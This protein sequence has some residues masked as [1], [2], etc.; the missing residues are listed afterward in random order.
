MT[1]QTIVTTQAELDAALDAPGEIII[2]SPRGVWLILNRGTVSV[3]GQSTVGPVGGSATVS[4]VGGSATVRGVWDSATVSDVWGSATVSGVGDSATVRDVGGS[5]TVH[6]YDAATAT[7]VGSHVA[8]HLHSA[9][10]TTDGGVVIDVAALDLTDIVTWAGYR[11]TRVR[12]GT[13]TAYKAVGADWQTHRK[14]WVYEPGATVTAADWDG[15]PECGGGLHLCARPAQ[16][17]RYYSTA[18]RY[19]EC[20]VAVADA[21]VVGDKLKARAVRVVCEVDIDGEPVAP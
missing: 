10:A 2:D 9:R 3:R 19:V 5:A 7:Q 18:T 11:G 4:D 13:V 15:K 6:L 1:T 16:S 8:V 12:T 14:G 17:R 20:E 21:V